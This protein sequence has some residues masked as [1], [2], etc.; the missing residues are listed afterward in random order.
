MS[1]N[2]DNNIQDGNFFFS[3]FLVFDYFLENFR[4]YAGQRLIY[5]SPSIEAFSK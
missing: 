1:I 5:D 2:K 3:F 4:V